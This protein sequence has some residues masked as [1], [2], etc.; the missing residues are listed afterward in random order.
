MRLGSSSVDAQSIT[1]A[2][3]DTARAGYITAGSAICH[4]LR[5]TRLQATTVN[6][7]KVGNEQLFGNRSA[8]GWNKFLQATSMSGQF[9]SVEIGVIIA[10]TRQKVRADSLV[11]ASNCKRA[12]RHNSLQRGI[13]IATAACIASTAR[14]VLAGNRP[15][16]IAACGCRIFS[17][18]MRANVHAFVT[19][20]S[21]ILI[22]E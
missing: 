9:Q 8:I 2:V 15:Q 20:K 1:R 18:I 19:R 16:P 22:R 10:A 7:W 12:T 17:P 21:T 14:F 5:V 13:A 11:I 4:R 3:S 6:A